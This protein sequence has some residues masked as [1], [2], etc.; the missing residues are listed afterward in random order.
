MIE[1]GQTVGPQTAAAV[2]RILKSR[3]HP[4]LGYRSCLGVLRLA[5]LHLW[6]SS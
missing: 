6:D 2:E 4:E 1:R 5:D 3:Q